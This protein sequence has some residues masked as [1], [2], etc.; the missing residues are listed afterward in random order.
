M[1]VQQRKVSKQKVRQRQAANRY[2]GMQSSPC[3]SCGAARRP[4]RVCMQ[5]G[6]YKD[7]QVVSITAE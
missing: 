2:Q 7:R 3:P 1:A 4:H 5:C 6:K